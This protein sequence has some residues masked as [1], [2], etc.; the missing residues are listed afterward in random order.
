MANPLLV[1]YVAVVMVTLGLLVN[2]RP[3]PEEAVPVMAVPG[4][5]EHASERELA[6]PPLWLQLFRPSPPTARLL[7]R[8]ALPALPMGRGAGEARNLQVLWTGP[9][10]P[11]TLF[12]V[13]L[14][15]LR[16]GTE[17]A[18]GPPAPPSRPPTVTP[19]APSTAKPPVSQP[20]PSSQTQTP[21]PAPPPAEE[22]ESLAVAGGVPLVG[23]YHTHDWE[24]YHSE[25]PA[26]ALNNPRDLS[27]IAS[28]DH[29]LRTIVDI[30]ETLAL[31]MRDM[32]VTTVHA[33]FK[34]QELGYDYAYSSSRNTARQILKE[35][36]SVKVLLDLHRDGTWGL[37]S[38]T[39][40]GG[41][42]VARLRCV[43]GKRDDQPN[44]QQNKSFCDSLMARLEEDYPGITLP[45]VTQEYRYNQDLIPGAILLEV[46]NA[47]NRYDEAERAVGYLANVLAEMIREGEYPK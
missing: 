46:G 14:P 43:I 37:D 4:Q 21:K 20:P 32:G 44:W 18:G 6:E 5:P 16:S 38:T 12:Q 11:Q 9:E 29:S 40:I 3:H 2:R 8:M 10:R 1:A 33:P 24:S 39:E 31:H 15:F 28:Y 36:P 45:T 41:E 42:K 27:K 13:A 23:I 30:G 26:L 35:A 17:V 25:F 19:P 22:K 34:H 47:T 7:L